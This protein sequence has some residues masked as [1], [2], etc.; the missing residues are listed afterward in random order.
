[1]GSRGAF[2]GRAPSLA[3]AFGLRMRL[4]FFAGALF[5]LAYLEKLIV[6]VIY[7]VVLTGGFATDEPFSHSFC[8][9]ELP[10][11]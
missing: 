5:W 6:P 11:T 3:P 9:N 10:E 8:S 7:R 1:M 4:S 2:W